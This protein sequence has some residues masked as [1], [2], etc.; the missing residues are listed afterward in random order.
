MR[1]IYTSGFF[2]FFSFLRLFKVFFRTRGECRTFLNFSFSP[3]NFEKLRV[4]IFSIQIHGIFEN[5][6]R[7]DL[8]IL[9]FHLGSLRFCNLDSL[10]TIQ[11]SS[12]LHDRVFWCSFQV[13]IQFYNFE[14]FVQFTYWDLVLF[15]SS[16]C[17]FII[18]KFLSNDAIEF[19]RQNFLFFHFLKFS[20]YRIYVRIFCCST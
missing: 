1:R 7:T 12:N 11:I 6:T 14:N 18:S 16:F 3:R 20:E 15:L 10:R 17:N 5:F 9:G 4:R 13:F 2:L 8:G 19:T